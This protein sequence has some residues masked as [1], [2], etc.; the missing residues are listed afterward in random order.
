VLETLT[1][2]GADIDATLGTDTG[3]A[4]AA[5]P[6]VLVETTEVRAARSWESFSLVLRGP[7][8]AFF[9]QGT[10]HFHH[11]VLGDFDMF[12]TAIR[13]DRQGF[14]YEAAFSRQRREEQLCA[15]PR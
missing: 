5:V 14:Y 3:D 9:P 7:A 1:P 6:L 12:F 10:Y 13:Q 4:G 15:P 2:S 11:G 8:D